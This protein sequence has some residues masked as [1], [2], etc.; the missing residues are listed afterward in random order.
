MLPCGL[1][2]ALGCAPRAESTAVVERGSW[3]SPAAEPEPCADVGTVRVCWDPATA[4]P[5]LR[6]RPVPARAPSTPLGWRCA[7]AGAARACR[8]RGRD[9]PPFVCAGT[10][11]RQRPPRLP[12]DGDWSCADMSGAVVCVGGAAP[13]GVAAAAAAPGWFCDE[14]R[15]RDEAGDASARVCVDLSPDYPDGEPARWRC[16]FDNAPAP[17]RVCQGAAEPRAV[18]AACA[19]DA[20]CPAG[21]ACVSGRCLPPRPSPGCWS[22]RDCAAPE[23]CQLGSCRGEAP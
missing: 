2:L 1:A 23:R 19:A 16:H 15:A 17:V 10:H 5:R 22:D 11:C 21:T 4:E 12:D 3:P 20:A 8:D 14:R 9:A 7:G 6:P 18:G 13:A